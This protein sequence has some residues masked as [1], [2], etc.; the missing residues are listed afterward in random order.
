MTTLNDLYT[1]VFLTALAIVA[2]AVARK[3]RDITHPVVVFFGPIYLQYLLYFFLYSD[4][5]RI[6][7]ITNALLLL[8][9]A[10]FM[11]GAAFNHILFHIAHMG[12]IKPNIM[13]IGIYKMHRARKPM[14]YIGVTGFFLGLYYAYD[15]GT[16]GP[17]SFFFNLRYAT[18]IEGANLGA[19]PYLLLFLHMWLIYSICIAPAIRR[20]KP[21]QVGLILMLLIISSL[22]TMARTGLFFTAISAAGAFYLSQR[23]LYRKTPESFVNIIIFFLTLTGLFILVAVLTQKAEVSDVFDSFL[24]YLAF[25]IISF[26]KFIAPNPGIHNGHNIFYPFWKIGELFGLLPNWTRVIPGLTTADFNA[27]TYL[28]APYLD[29]GKQGV[30]IVSFVIGAT[31]SFIYGNARSGKPFYIALYSLLLFPLFMAFYEYQFSLVSWIYYMIIL[32]GSYALTPKRPMEIRQT[33]P[34]KRKTTVPSA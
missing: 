15:M 5:H 2:A 34:L 24:A 27:F 10:S 23:Y 18:T 9:A 12:K 21:Y 1:L 11:L 6:T 13:N 32:V 20:L 25:P 29:F 4:E 16:S 14:L 3:N 19:A 33:A 31:V 28:N 7:S 17:S 30:G 22:F 26:D 8:G